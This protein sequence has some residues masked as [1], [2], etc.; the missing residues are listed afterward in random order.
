MSNY[1]TSRLSSS[2][3]YNYILGTVLRKVDVA[4]QKLHS[5]QLMLTIKKHI[6]EINY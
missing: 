3:W 2:I 4:I 1:Y 6:A 5:L